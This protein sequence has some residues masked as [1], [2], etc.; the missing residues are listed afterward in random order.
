MPRGLRTA[1]LLA[2]ADP[3]RPIQSHLKRAISAV[4]LG[5]FDA[6][7]PTVAEAP[8]GRARRG[9]TAWRRVHRAPDLGRAREDLKRIAA[10]G[11][12]WSPASRR[13]AD[14][15]VSEQ[16]QR[17]RADRDS[18]PSFSRPNMLTAIVEAAAAFAALRDLSTD[19]RLELAA[20]LLFRCRP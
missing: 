4:Y 12:P 8:V 16:E 3:R 20:W 7:A 1:R 14:L 11:K 9:R 2:Q 15:F 17:Y 13:L 5:L 19:E 6:L 18:I 10:D